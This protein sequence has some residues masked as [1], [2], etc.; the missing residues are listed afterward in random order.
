MSHNRVVRVHISFRNSL[1]S[2]IRLIPTTATLTAKHLAEIFFEKWYCENG[3][4]LDIVSDRDKLFVSRFWK[5]LHELTSIKLKMSSGYHPETD[6]ASER[7]N[8]TVIQCL[9]FRVERDQKGWVKAL[10][11]VR[12]DIM[13]TIN[14]STGFSP[15]QLRFG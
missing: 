2:D 9:H 13:N 15:F 5:A 10:L 12:F 11:K 7:T 6:G 14:K 3:L 8:K 1:G 4:P